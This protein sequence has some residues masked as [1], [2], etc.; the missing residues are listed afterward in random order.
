MGYVSSRSGE[1]G[2]KVIVSVVSLQVAAGCLKENGSFVL[3]SEAEV[4]WNR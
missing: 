3:V 1:D 2:E 4:T